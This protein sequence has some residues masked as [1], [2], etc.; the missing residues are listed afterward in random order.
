MHRVVPEGRISPEDAGLWTDSQIA[1]IKR[2]VDFTHA[3]GVKIGVQL[4]HAGRKASTHAPT[5]FAPADALETAPQRLATAEEN[6]WPDNGACCLL[7]EPIST[8]G[9]PVYGPSPITWAEGYAKPKELTVDGIRLVVNAFVASAQRTLQAGCTHPYSRLLILGLT[10]RQLTSSRS[11]R[12]MAIFSIPSCHRYRMS[13]QISTEAALR[14]ILA[15][16][17]RSFELCAAPSPTT[18]RSSVV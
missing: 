4:A 10:F 9:L 14:T 2:C 13:G 3:Q 12:L 11:T 7:R 5:V 18:C 16:S 6:G 17:R 1:P 8:D 15:L